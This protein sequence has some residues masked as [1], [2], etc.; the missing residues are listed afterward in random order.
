MY[1]LTNLSPRVSVNSALVRPAGLTNT[2][3]VVLGKWHQQVLTRNS[4]SLMDT[5]DLSLMS[6]YFSA[7]SFA[8]LLMMNSHLCLLDEGLIGCY[9]HNPYDDEQV[10][11]F[12]NLATSLSSSKETKQRVL[13]RLSNLHP[14]VTHD[15]DGE[16]HSV[17]IQ[18]D[19]VYLV[20]DEGVLSADN[21]ESR[22][23]TIVRDTLRA[24]Y[25]LNSISDVTGHPLFSVYLTTIQN[26]INTKLV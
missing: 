18:D 14:M 25:T 11:V 5:R 2:N 15:G 23:D 16:L 26:Q 9:K 21:Y 10:G 20:L 4:L 24:C 17:I 22:L 1:E 8:E 19:V 12:Y 6:Q 13:S 3:I 7:D